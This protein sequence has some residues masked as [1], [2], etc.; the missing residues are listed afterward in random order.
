MSRSK[1]LFMLSGSVAGFK[2]CQ[3]ISKLVQD[4][5][6]VQTVTTGSALQFIGPATL[7]GLTGKKPLCDLWEAGTAME[8]IH[9]TRWADIAVLCPATAN[10]LAK[11]AHGMADDL[12][13]AL[14][15]AWPK[16]KPFHVFPAMNSVMLSNPATQDNLKL[17]QSRGFKI[18]ACGAGNLACGEEGDGRLLE[19]EQIVATL[20]NAVSASPRPPLA[21]RGRLLIT[22]GATREPIDGIRFISNVSTGQTGAELADLMTARGYNVTYLHGQGAVRPRSAAHQVPFTDFQDLDRKLKVELDQRDYEAVIHAAAVS[23]Y[24]LE[25]PS[26]QVKLS[27]DQPQLTLQLKPNPKLLPKLK[28]Y[29]RKAGL[30]VI[31]FKLTLNQAESDG[32]SKARALLNPA[33]DAVVANDWSQVD[34]DRSRHPGTLVTPH[35]LMKFN[36]LSELAA[37]LEALLTPKQEAG[38]DLMS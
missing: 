28:S 34:R 5:H 16:G 35:G 21:S 36:T 11:I 9:L 8:H 14:A 31:G 18:A 2:A 20:T 13:T 27:S 30:K 25:N 32:Q 4:G 10:T 29:S 22:A 19:P 38:H 33:V 15:L 37:G 26:A 7:E 1:I 23:D 24:S 12:V 6:E 17:L 3:A